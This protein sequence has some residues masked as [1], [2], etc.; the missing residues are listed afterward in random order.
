MFNLLS[1]KD[2]LKLKCFGI[3]TQRNSIILWNKKT[4]RNYTNFILWN[5]KR[6]F[7]LCNLLYV[8]I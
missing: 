3:S 4:G 2:E 7:E 1:N 6:P 5:D 8:Y